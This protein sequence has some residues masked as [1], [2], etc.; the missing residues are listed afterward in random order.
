MSG[1]LSQ[2]AG[3]VLVVDDDASVRKALA[4]L[5]QSAGWQART[6]ASAGEFLDHVPP[7]GPACLVLDVRMPGLSGLDLQAE[8]A[9]RNLQTP[10][11]FITGHGNVP[12]SVQAMKGGAVDFLIKP[13]KDQDLLGVIQEALQKDARLQVDRAE[14][15]AIQ[16]RLQTLTEREHE[17]LLQVVKGKMNKEIADAFGVSE[18]T[19]KVHRGRVMHKMQVCSV[20]ELVQAVA[21]VQAGGLLP[22]TRRTDGTTKG[23]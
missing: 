12:M 7:A 4:R 17:V 5:I 23:L 6:F 22:D 3:T 13:F 14:R 1:R 20:A 11:I 9:S 16:G 2:A 8:M 21:Q 15:A 19:V 10:I 18:A